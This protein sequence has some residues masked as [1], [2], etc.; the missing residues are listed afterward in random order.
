MRIVLMGTGNTATVLG[1]LMKKCGHELLQ[2]YGRTSSSASALASELGTSFVSTPEDIV[3]SADIYIIAVSDNA[4]ADLARKIQIGNR[5][6]VHTAGA[7]SKHVL[8]QASRNYGVLYPLQSLRKEMDDLPPVPFLVDGNTSEDLTLLYDFAGSLSTQVARANDELRLH[9]H[10]AAVLS[11]NFSNHLYTLAE[12]Y[13]RA[14]QA[15]FQLLLPLIQQLAWRLNRYS[16]SALQT[17]PALRGDSATI[18]LH[19]RLLEHMPE[20]KNLYTSI[21]ESIQDHYRRRDN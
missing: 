16:P 7:V 20:T 17:G 14:N 11:N 19:L 3:S 6:L 13:C 10:L 8:Q 4:I 21:T 12:E 1:R 5:L 9:Y 18:E 15:D 2:V